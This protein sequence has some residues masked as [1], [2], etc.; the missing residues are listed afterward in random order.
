MVILDW[1]TSAAFKT[2]SGPIP[3][4]INSSGEENIPADKIISFLARA[5]CGKPCRE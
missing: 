1:Y 4:F 2:L 3:D 5:I